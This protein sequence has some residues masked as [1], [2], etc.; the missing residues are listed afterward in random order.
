MTLNINGSE[1]KISVKGEFSNKANKEDTMYFLNELCC[2]LGEA[3]RRYEE[4]GLNALAETAET[5]RHDIHKELDAKG[6]YK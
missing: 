6:F 1:V 5:A 3:R 2:Y 4:L